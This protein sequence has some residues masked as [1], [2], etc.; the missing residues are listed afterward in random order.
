MSHEYKGY[1]IEIEQ[2][3]CAPNPRREFDE[4]GVMVCWHGRYDLGDEKTESYQQSPDDFIEWA[5]GSKEIALILPLYLYE[6]SGLRIKVGSFNG[7]LPQGHAEFDTMQ[8]GFIYVT[9]DALRKEYGK[10]RLSKKTLEHARRVLLNEVEVYDQYLS[11]DVWAY[12]IDGV[13]SCGGFFGYDVC[14]KDAQGMIDY[15]IEH[16]E[17]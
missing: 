1:T 9:K 13:D 4:L 16:S 12:V 11:G 6:H 3:E 15:H 10:T 14:L 2:D 7:L 5:E 8:V 17:A